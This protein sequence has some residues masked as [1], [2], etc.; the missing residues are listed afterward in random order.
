M[1]PVQ[2]RKD[3]AIGQFNPTTSSIPTKL[4]VVRQLDHER[5]LVEKAFG[6][7]TERFTL[8]NGRGGSAYTPGP[9]YYETN[10]SK[11]SDSASGLNSLASP[12]QSCKGYGI[13]FVSK[14][15]RFEWDVRDDEIEDP[16]PASPGP[17]YYN[18]QQAEEAIRR[19]PRNNA[20]VHPSQQM[21]E[22]YSHSRE[23][24]RIRAARALA[25]YQPWEVP[26]PGTYET[27]K[28]TI[29]PSST[30][31]TYASTFKSS[32]RSSISSNQRRSRTAGGK[33]RPRTK[34]TPAPGAY[35][36]PIAYSHSAVR[37]DGTEKGTW[38]FASTSTRGESKSSRRNQHMSIAPSVYDTLPT[39]AGGPSRSVST[40]PVRSYTASARARPQKTGRGIMSGAIR[41]EGDSS[42]GE[43]NKQFLSTTTTSPAPGPG[44]YELPTSVVLKGKQQQSAF[45]S[46]TKRNITSKHQR[47]V[48]GPAFYSVGTA[49]TKRSFLLNAGRKWV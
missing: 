12:S 44:S 9:G 20:T 37:K 13:G 36:H 39:G 34:E 29:D 7:Q 3:Q 24:A 18:T 26:G 27:N 14:T 1:S 15:K 10:T 30:S 40:Q 33:R 31:R 47:M 35:Y 17:G 19:G 16:K 11:L 22:E 48:P 6:S 25:S 43:S 32:S 49:P 38:T 21:D 46:R 4:H 28:A 45:K 41:R 8:T 2:R 23:V 5:G 42:M